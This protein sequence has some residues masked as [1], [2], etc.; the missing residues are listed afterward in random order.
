MSPIKVYLTSAIRGIGL[1]L[2]TALQ[3]LS[4]KFPGKVE[5]LRLV[6]ADVQRHKDVANLIQDKHGYVDVVIA[7]TVGLYDQLSTI[8]A[9]PSARFQS[10]YSADTLKSTPQGSSFSSKPSSLSSKRASRRPSL[11]PSRSITSGGGSLT[12]YIDQSY[13]IVAYGASKATL[14]YITR[15]IHF[16]N[17]WLVAFPLSPGVVKTDM[18]YQAREMDKKGEMAKLQD[19]VF[20]SVEDASVMLVNI[21]DIATREKEGG[22]LVNV[23]GGRIPW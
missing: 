17:E 5:I 7:N 11:F 2:A 12:A 20:I 15:R 4:A 23:D 14:N 6:S 8:I 9:V 1:G 16:E 13:E 21:I 18:T 22:E 10:T 3:E 19:Q